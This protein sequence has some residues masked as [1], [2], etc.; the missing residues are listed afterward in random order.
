[1]F[2]VAESRLSHIND[3]VTHALGCY[4]IE[5]VMCDITYVMCYVVCAVLK[6]T[7]TF[8]RFFVHCLFE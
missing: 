1:M 8:I 4:A 6:V 5:D 2:Y 7:H 3:N